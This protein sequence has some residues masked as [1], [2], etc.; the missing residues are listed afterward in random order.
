[1]SKKI[2]LIGKSFE[3]LT[4]IDLFDKDRDHNLKWLCLCKCNNEIIV[5]GCNL[6]SGHTKSCGCL[7]KN[8]AS[9]AN[10]THG[11]SQNDKTYKTWN[12]MIQ[13]CTN[14]NNKDYKNYGGRGIKVY[15]R[16]LKFEIFY[17]DM[18]DAP[19][20][21]QIDRIHN[22][23]GYFKKNCRW[24]TPKQ[25]NNNKRNNHYITAFNKTQTMMQWS[26][27]LGIPYT[28]LKERINTYKWTIN[29]ALTTTVRRGR[30]N[31]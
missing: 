9:M 30:I 27:E 21:L 4:V 7:Q 16:W 22:D 6:R 23:K 24:S 11:H 12:Q 15:K 18:G 2:D 26:E 8:M 3:R 19:P 14:P 1:M 17:E 29:R 20:G 25:N 5:L 28:T 31:Q 10:I 13:R